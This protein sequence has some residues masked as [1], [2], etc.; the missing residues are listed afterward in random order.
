MPQDGTYIDTDHPCLNFN[1]HK[2]ICFLLFLSFGLS[3]TATGI[4]LPLY[5]YPGTNAAIWAPLKT[6]ITAYPSVQWQIIINPN[7]GPG[8]KP[9]SPYP[10]TNYIAGIKALKKYS[11]VKTLGYVHTS[12]GR[13]PVNDIR[14]DINNYTN[15][16][17]YTNGDISMDGMFDHNPNLELY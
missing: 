13:R 14:A 17:S 7:N 6:A 1:H 3:V 12:Y 15:W 16:S 9:S 11:N 4:L 5:V 10:D 8:T 2:M